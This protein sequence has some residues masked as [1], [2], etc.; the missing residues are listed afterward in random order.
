MARAALSSPN[1]E[2]DILEHRA[3]SRRT[4]GGGGRRSGIPRLSNRLAHHHGATLL[5]DGGWSAK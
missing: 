5:V 3:W 4:A 1:F 2:R